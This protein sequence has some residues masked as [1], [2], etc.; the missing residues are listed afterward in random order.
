[1]QNVRTLE[2]GIDRQSL[3]GLVTDDAFPDELLVPLQSLAS[4]VVGRVTN[5]A[6]SVYVASDD[7]DSDARNQFAFALARSVMTHVPDLLMIDCDFLEVGLSGAVP[8][9]DG[10]G[11]LDLLL[12]GSSL[13]AITQ[14]AVGGVTVIGAGSFPVSK[15]SPFVM[16]AFISAQRYLLN[17]SKCLIYSGPVT[18]DDDK[19]HPI[20]EHID[21]PVIVR[22][23]RRARSDI[24]DPVEDKVSSATSDPVWSVRIVSP[25]PGTEPERTEETADS[26]SESSMSI[27]SAAE[28]AG[29][30]DGEDDSRQPDKP[31]PAIAMPYAGSEKTEAPSRKPIEAP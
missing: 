3:E 14:Q 21:L 9:R 7:A 31:R 20:I 26:P 13:G 30:T 24:L 1:M 8:H 6:V 16:D 4:D 18:D 27:E 5:G 22:K 29:V 23:G 19:V 11:F 17:Q 28:A 2:F 12:Y 25:G 15:K 10:L